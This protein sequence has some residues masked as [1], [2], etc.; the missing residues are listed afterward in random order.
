MLSYSLMKNSRK[1]QDKNKLFSFSRNQISMPTSQSDDANDK[2][3]FTLFLHTD[4]S[5]PLNYTASSAT[6]NINVFLAICILCL[7]LLSCMSSGFST[8][9]AI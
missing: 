6:S 9:Q 2:T 8:A 1:H 5:A 4:A 3:V 7:C